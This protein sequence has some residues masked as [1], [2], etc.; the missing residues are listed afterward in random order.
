MCLKDTDPDAFAGHVVSWNGHCFVLKQ[1]FPSSPFLD[2]KFQCGWNCNSECRKLGLVICIFT[3]VLDRC[4]HLSSV[5]CNCL[6]LVSCLL[7]SG[8]TLTVL[9]A[10]FRRLGNTQPNLVNIFAELRMVTTAYFLEDNLSIHDVL[11][12][13]HATYG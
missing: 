5:F 12:G 1:K 11:V 4:N 9:R 8:Y 2:R 3:N 10:A 7:G 6:G 13:A